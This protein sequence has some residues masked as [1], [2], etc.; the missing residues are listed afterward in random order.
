MNHVVKLCALFA[1]ALALVGCRQRAGYGTYLVA[2]ES[3][4]SQSGTEASEETQEPEGEPCAGMLVVYVCGEVCAPGVYELP[5]G[6][7]I[8]DAAEAAGGL[9]PAASPDY[10]NLAQPL[11]D[12]EMICFPDREAAEERREAAEEADRTSE[13]SDGRVNLNTATLEQLVALPGIGETR[14][15]AILAYR[16]RNGAFS[17]TEEIMQVS[18][19]G[20]A[21]FENMRDYITVD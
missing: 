5:A 2:S 13:R 17:D 18:G 9:T 12:G 20:S 7:R 4:R 1:V 8:C 21:V 6:S 19:I 3:E 15:R 10:W 14:G 16:D 11:A